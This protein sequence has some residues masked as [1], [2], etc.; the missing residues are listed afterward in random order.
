VEWPQV[1]FS[2]TLQSGAVRG[3][4]FQSAPSA[5]IKLITCLTGAVFDVLVDV[6]P[7]SSTFGKWRAFE[8]SGRNTVGLYVPAGFA[9]GFQCLSDDCRLVYMMSCNYRAES[10]KG[11]HYNDPDLSVSW[12]LPVS[13]VSPKDEALPLLQA[14]K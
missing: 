9:H 12:P 6:R 2:H 11:V 4:H 8:L 7:S 14:L 3:L 1:N 10:A 13:C 5:E